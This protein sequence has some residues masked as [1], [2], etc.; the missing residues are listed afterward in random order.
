MKRILTLA[1]FFSFTLSHAQNNT[2]ILPGH[3]IHGGLLY[4]TQTYNG[5][6]FLDYQYYLDDQISYSIK[7]GMTGMLIQ[8]DSSGI[9]LSAG[10]NFRFLSLRKPLKD[11]F[12]NAEPYAGFYPFS[13][14]FVMINTDN[15]DDPDSRFG[16]TP[17]GIIGC[18]LIFANRIDLDFH[19]GFG[20]SFRMAGKAGESLQPVA[21]AGLS[22]G[23][24]F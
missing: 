1:L 22:L 9:F 10:M 23:Y 7:A 20:L 16:L 2:N 8:N 24:R 14:D 4:T 5:G 19:G 15:E 21:Y 12:F 17:S 18:T 13:L 6:P 11:R 3:S